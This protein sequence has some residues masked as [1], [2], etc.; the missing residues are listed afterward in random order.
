MA[1]LL[2]GASWLGLTVEARAA[3]SDAYQFPMRPGTPAWSALKTHGE[4]LAATQVPLSVLKEMSTEGLVE[5]CLDYP[6]LF[7]IYLYSAPQDGFEKVSARFNGL[8][9]LLLRS[10]AGA[11]LV[12]RYKRVD[13]AA[14][15]EEW[16]PSQRGQHAAMLGQ[17]EL[18]LAQYSVLRGMVP[19]L[20][21]ELLAESLRKTEAK[22]VWPRTF[23]PSG[24]ERTA[25]LVGRVLEAQGLIGGTHIW[26]SPT[27][28]RAQAF[29]STGLGADPTLVDAILGAARKVLQLPPD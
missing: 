19:A 18:M 4:M 12:Q 27:R 11:Q 26:L 15:P 13:P 10:D 2:L 22:R 17:L 16:G 25:F 21:L 28:E 6:L 8:Q 5:T 14:I 23:G 20:R 7:E 29:L 9:E 1:A 3:T 24:Q